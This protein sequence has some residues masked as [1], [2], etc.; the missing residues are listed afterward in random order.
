MSYELSGTNSAFRTHNSELGEAVDS[1]PRTQNSELLPLVYS[2]KE[3][4]IGF[5]QN[6]FRFRQNVYRT[7]RYGK[8]CSTNLPNVH[9]VL[10]FR[11]FL[12]IHRQRGNTQAYYLLSYG[13]EPCKG[14]EPSDLTPQNNTCNSNSTYTRLVGTCRS[15]RQ[16]K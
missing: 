13:A 15:L 3:N 5:S 2:A 4:Q 8:S 9:P 7:T 6:R 12:P 11:V 14:T 16:K 10:S 1:E